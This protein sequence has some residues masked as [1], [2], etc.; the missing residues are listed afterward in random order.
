MITALF[1]SSHFLFCQVHL[2]SL[3]TLYQIHQET[4][5][6]PKRILTPAGMNLLFAEEIAYFLSGSR[7]LSL[8]NSYASTSTDDDRLFLAYNLSFPRNQTNG[9][10][11]QLLTFGVEADIKDGIS[12]FVKNSEFTNNVGVRVKWTWMNDGKVNFKGSKKSKFH[13]KRAKI[14]NDI[15]KEIIIPAEAIIKIIGDS[16][17]DKI[18]SNKLR[19]KAVQEFYKR[20]VSEFVKSKDFNSFGKTWL[21][22][23]MY[24]PVSNGQFS[25]IDTAL[26]KIDKRKSWL[27]ESYLLLNHYRKF[28]AVK[29]VGTIG[30]EVNNY[31]SVL[32]DKTIKLT[33]TMVQSF[34]NTFL[35]NELGTIYSGEFNNFISPRMLVDVAVFPD[36]LFKN[37]RSPFGF[38]LE[39]R[40]TLEVNN[41]GYSP[42]LLKVGVPVTLLDKEGSPKI[43]FE[44][45]IAWEDGDKFWRIGI[46]L[47]FGS[48]GYE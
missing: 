40:R 39:V 18:E 23:S 29:L 20:E 7:D 4:F 43:N 41:N 12:N 8:Y 5:D 33:Q 22:F 35:N 2:N 28:P 46:A 10:V 27:F 25:M 42:T 3:D 30:M 6:H 34:N 17:V 16:D 47:P 11:S 36:F 38:S 13:N 45:Q 26:T 14:I 19:K 44:P 32:A 21:T 15:N 9:Y 24:L 1:L 37:R 48:I 31:N